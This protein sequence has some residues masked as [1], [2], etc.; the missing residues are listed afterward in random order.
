PSSLLRS[1]L[2][3]GGTPARA[4]CADCGAPCAR[5]SF[6]SRLQTSSLARE[7][8]TRLRALDGVAEGAD[9]K[10]GVHREQQRVVA[11]G[12]PHDLGDPEDHL[13]PAVRGARCAKREGY[14]LC[15][16]QCGLAGTRLRR[17]RHRGAPEASHEVQ[18]AQGK[19]HR[20]TAREAGVQE[21][22][23]SLRPTILE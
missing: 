22:Q 2:L 16:K 18:V 11:S 15:T 13:V 14:V 10:I 17:I 23:V 19:W 6:R 3:A 8:S 1:P 4:P 12:E 9:E 5:G 20:L 7:G 21:L